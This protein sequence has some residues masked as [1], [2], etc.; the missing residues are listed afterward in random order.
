MTHERLGRLL[1]GNSVL[2]AVTLAYFHHAAWLLAVAVTAINLIQSA[3][4]DRCPVKSLLIRFGLPGERELGCAES[5]AKAREEGGIHVD[6]KNTYQVQAVKS[7]ER[8]EVHA[9][10]PGGGVGREG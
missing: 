2:M 7:S 9:G 5:L 10:S 8:L 4:T 6:Q 1:A 3:L